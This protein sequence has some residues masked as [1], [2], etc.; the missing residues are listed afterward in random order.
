LVLDPVHHI[1]PSLDGRPIL[2]V[3]VPELQPWRHVT[4]LR[5]CC[6]L[7]FLSWFLD[8][9]FFL[10]FFLFRLL[11][12]LLPRL[13]ILFLFLCSLKWI[14]LLLFLLVDTFDVLLPGTC[15][16][17]VVAVCSSARRTVF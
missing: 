6:V 8:L 4:F 13:G 14:F 11:V 15:Y 1:A 12:A 7:Y 10:L 3:A 17:L 16:F 2:A 9:V 5:H